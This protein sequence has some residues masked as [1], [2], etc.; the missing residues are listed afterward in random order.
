[1]PADIDIRA[2]TP[3]DLDDVLRLLRAQFTAHQLAPAEDGLARLVA[4]VLAGGDEGAFLVAVTAGRVVGV[5]ALSF[6]WP[7]E[8]GERSAWLEELYVEPAMRNAGIGARLLDAATRFAR[9]A[10]ATT[11]DLEVAAGHEDAG[12]LYA[13]AGFAPLPRSHWMRRL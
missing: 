3:A 12:R 7:L 11:M 1:M 4:R 9:D 13:R 2:A 6:A 5:A 8:R 10:G